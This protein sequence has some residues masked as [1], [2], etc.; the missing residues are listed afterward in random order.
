MKRLL[1]LLLVM[2]L[3]T[4]PVM[5]V[6]TTEYEDNII[7]T[8][9]LSEQTVE[10][11]K[12]HNIDLS[13]FEGATVYPEDH[14]IQYNTSIESIILQTKAYGFSDEQV[15]AMVKGTINNKPT[16]IG[17]K[18][19][20]T[21]RVQIAVPSFDFYINNEKIDYKTSEYP[22]ITYKDITYFPMTWDY[23]RMLGVTTEWSHEE[24]FKVKVEETSANVPNYKKNSNDEEY[25]YAE[26]PE[27]PIYIN[28]EKIEIN[29]DV[30]PI[31]N[32]RNITYFPMTEEILSKL[33]WEYS[34]SDEMVSVSQNTV[35]EL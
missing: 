11:L 29:K 2:V 7:K 32:F 33:E 31:L 10:F 13:I 27:Y 12:K 15:L 25:L 22:I 30:N 19:D 9:K 28:N 17:G 34:V 18:Y 21:G 16:I 3:L 24:G 35:N 23:A 26:V 14:P 5:A 1:S 4:M 6:T 20:N 8:Y